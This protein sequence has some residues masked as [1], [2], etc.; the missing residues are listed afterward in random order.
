MATIKAKRFSLTP[1]KSLWKQAQ[2]QRERRKAMRENL[3]AFSNGIAGKLEA[4]QVNRVNGTAK[5]ALQ[6]GKDRIT[7]AVGAAT[8][9]TAAEAQAG[10][11]ILA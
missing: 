5:L 9:K 4:A 2:V 6:A 11:D 10:L 8:A 3:E 1:R 7:A